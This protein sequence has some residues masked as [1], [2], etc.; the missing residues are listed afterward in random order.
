MD[1]ILTDDRPLTME[2]KENSPAGQFGYFIRISQYFFP[3]ILGM[4]GYEY[5]EVLKKYF[6]QFFLLL[7]GVLLLLTAEFMV[8]SD[9]YYAV[10]IQSFA[11]VIVVV[12]CNENRFAN[13]LDM[14]PVVWLGKTSYSFYLYHPVAAYVFFSTMIPGIL[15]RYLSESLVL[16]IPFDTV[17]TVG[18]AIFL[19]W[20]SYKFVELPFLNPRH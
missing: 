14:K 16:R 15:G 19:G 17:A 2:K 12:G 3:F 1:V 11:S 20:L 5:Y 9:S 13:F 10:F 18:L 6:S 4:Y 7:L 8:G